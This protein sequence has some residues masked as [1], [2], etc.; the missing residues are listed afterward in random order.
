MVEAGPII[1]AVRPVKVVVV[2]EV[3]V[4]VAV[5]V[6]SG[7]VVWTMAVDAV[8]G[9]VVVGGET[10]DVVDG[11]KL[12]VDTTIPPSLTTINPEGA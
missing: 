4:V 1:V 6:V 5:N 7:T 11:M 9:V 10:V 2:V 3:T 8:A 12:A